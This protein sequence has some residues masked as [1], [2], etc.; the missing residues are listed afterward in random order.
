[1]DVV[2]TQGNSNIIWTGV[3][4]VA[5]GRVRVSGREQSVQGCACNNQNSPRLLPQQSC[6][7]T[8]FT[9]GRS[10][11]AGALNQS[12]ASSLSNSLL[13]HSL[14]KYAR[15]ELSEQPC[16]ARSHRGGP[17]AQ[18]VPS[19]GFSQAALLLACVR[20]EEAGG[21]SQ[22]CSRGTVTP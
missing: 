3:W 12:C 16:C 7:A 10:D 17:A 4:G 11:L 5:K 18:A 2:S 13:K 21:G 22:L 9:T 19:P 8:A 14:E 20:G 6:A 15:R 1:M